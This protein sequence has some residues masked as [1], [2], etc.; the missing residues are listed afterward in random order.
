MT[1]REI[2]EWLERTS[3]MYDGNPTAELLGSMAKSVLEDCNTE[4]RNAA[5]VLQVAEPIRHMTDT[6]ITIRIPL[7]FAIASLNN[8]KPL[9]QALYPHA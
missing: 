1:K 2:G 8:L 3:R 5:A 4:E 6:D 7:E 9:L